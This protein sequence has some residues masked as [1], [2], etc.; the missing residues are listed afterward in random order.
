VSA[1]AHNSVDCKLSSDET[2]SKKPGDEEWQEPR[3][4]VPEC[5]SLGRERISG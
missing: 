5:F 2:R 4:L 1:P 3:V